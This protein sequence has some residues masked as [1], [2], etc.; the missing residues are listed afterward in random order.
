MWFL[1]VLH[2]NAASFYT[3]VTNDVSRRLSEHQAGKGARYTRA[4]LPVELV[5][6]WRFPDRSAAQ[7]GEAKFKKL[8]RMGKEAWIEGRWPFLKAPFAF[9]FFDAQ[10]THHFCPRCGGALVLHAV[11]KIYIP[12]CTICGR[13]HYA[14][15]KPCAGL[16][17]LRDHQVL[18]VRRKM[19]PYRGYW[20]IPGGFL[21]ERELPQV[22]ALREAREETGLDVDVLDFLGFYMDDYDFQEER[23]A[24]LNIYFVGTAEGKPQA[25]DDAEE[26]AWFPLEA[27]PDKIAFDH[28][29]LVLADLQRWVKEQ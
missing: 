25:G 20:D 12:R 26:C 19:A 14:N 24:I 13:Q 18:L 21:E 1:Y 10:P 6:V 23:Y 7:R 9:E 11:E 4:H 16:L 29:P 28:E 5:A 2:C 22:G 17:I 3:G 27:L 8:S 15:A